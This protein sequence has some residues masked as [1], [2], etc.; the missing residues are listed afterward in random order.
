MGGVGESGMTSVVAVWLQ[1]GGW[2]GDSVVAVWLQCVWWQCGC[3]VVAVWLQCG[4]IVWVTLPRVRPPHPRP[5]NPC[6]QPARG[7]CRPPPATTGSRCPSCRR[8]RAT[9]APCTPAGDGLCRK[10]ADGDVG[11]NKMPSFF[12]SNAFSDA[13]RHSLPTY[14][15]ALASLLFVYWQTLIFLK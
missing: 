11:S 10:V 12:M 2:C 13:L 1:C 15:F 8:W 3:R 6:P 7:W 9:P 14:K 4:C 5:A